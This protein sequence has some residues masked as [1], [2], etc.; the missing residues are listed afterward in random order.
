M[1]Q[2]SLQRILWS[3][4]GSS[5]C[6]PHLPS[7]HCRISIATL[8]KVALCPYLSCAHTCMVLAIVPDP[9]LHSVHTCSVHNGMRSGSTLYPPVPTSALSIPHWV[10]IHTVLTTAQFLPLYC[11]RS[12]LRQ[13][14]TPIAW[15]RTC[16][17]HQ[18]I[19]VLG[20]ILK[21]QVWILSSVFFSLFACFLMIVVLRV[22]YF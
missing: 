17:H 12:L 18:K 2:T 11:G 4:P 9:Y 21:L 8:C 6:N 1:S 13:G 15:G 19:M 20:A 22:W 10:Y 14:V 7:V 5:L 16:A 3:K